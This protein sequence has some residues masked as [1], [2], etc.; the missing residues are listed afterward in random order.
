M[1]ANSKSVAIR[2]L[3]LLAGGGFLWA[4]VAVTPAFAFD[5]G[6]GVYGSGAYNIGQLD[7]T[8]TILTS[9]SN[10]STVGDSIRLTA[11]VT[12]ST[13]TGTI[14]FKDGN[15]TLGTATLGHASGSL[16][17]SALVAST[18]ALTAI[19]SGNLSHSG[20]TS[21]IV[22]QVVSA[23]AVTSESTGGEVG[24]GGGGGR[25][26]LGPP[27]A[28]SSTSS[29]GQSVTVWDEATLPQQRDF[30]QVI[31]EGKDVVFRD[32]KVSDWFARS[33]YELVSA[34]IV[35]GYRDARGRLTGEFGSANPV[36][37]AEIAK[38]ALLAAGKPLATG[39]PRNRSAR[40]NWS[41]AYVKTAEDLSLSVYT[42]SLDVRQ[43]ATRGEV[44]QTLL[45]AF[46][47][48][49]ALGENPFSDLRASNPHAAAIQTAYGLGI[50]S[51]D[52][53]ANGKATGTV[54]PNDPINRAEVAK[55]VV[56]M[57]EMVGK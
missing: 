10:P 44:I 52:T 22:T 19:Y 24:G 1:A 3:R 7:P 42:P 16:T 21:N 48:P 43:P 11:T 53:D 15:T 56:R 41:A 18:H 39:T 54:R 2:L 13:A 27:K 36:T 37:Y 45:E 46:A 4:L 25:R 31:V 49:I 51:G 9:S 6:R 50:V 40:D 20:S 5:Y 14:T 57:M 23:A 38:V 28:A 17:T 29:A 32:V 47:V 34:G 8:T 35:S 26:T 30:L 33:V 12:P 55:L